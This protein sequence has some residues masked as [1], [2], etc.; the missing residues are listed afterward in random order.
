M[1]TQ[2]NQTPIFGMYLRYSSDELQ[3]DK[4]IKDQQV[5]CLEYIDKV[6]GYIHDDHIFFDEGESGASAFRKYYQK[7]LKAIENG[8]FQFLIAES[9]ERLS[10]NQGDLAKLYEL[11]QFHGVKIIT[12]SEGNN[13]DEM[14]IAVKGMQSAFFLKD[15]SY[16]TKRGLRGRVRAG[17][18][19]GSCPYGY[20]P[21]YE[22][23][24]LTNK[25]VTGILNK[26]DHECAVVVDIFV[27]YI[28]G[29]SPGS[30]AKRLNDKGISGPGGR[31]W[32]ISTIRTILGNETYAGRRTWG[33]TR[34]VKDPSTGNIISRKNPESEWLVYEDEALRVI[35]DNVWQAAQARREE[36]SDKAC[37][38]CTSN[39]L[40]GMRRTK[41]ALSGKLFCSE[42]G[43]TYTLGSKNR[44]NCSEYKHRRC[45]NGKSKPLDI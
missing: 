13:I 28:E 15:L 10:R 2:T 17:K 40:T 26:V 25:K 18:N 7:M 36:I 34:N 27:W 30:I 24:L 33:K 16:K 21:S 14:F 23:D 1:N 29:M 8:E 44:Y 20:R 22:I 5:E 35:G 42:C 3:N 32:R 45:K 37:H 11:C 19:A 31:L 38:K 12:L 6:G 9:I 39:K 43:A 4:S 41:Y